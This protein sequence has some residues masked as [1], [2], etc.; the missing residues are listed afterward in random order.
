MEIQIDDSNIDSTTGA[1]TVI[2]VND[3]AAEIV[4]YTLML[5]SALYSLL[6]TFC[7]K[8]KN[9]NPEKEDSED[10][11]LL[12]NEKTPIS[13]FIDRYFSSLVLFSNFVNAFVCLFVFVFSLKSFRGVVCFCSLHVLVTG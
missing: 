11:K 9:H 6:Q 4:L 13:T 8:A 5:L 3:F 7:F 2:Q 12:L 10:A 1:W